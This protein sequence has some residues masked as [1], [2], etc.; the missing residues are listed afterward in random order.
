MTM[1]M[2]GN[3]ECGYTARNYDELNVLHKRYAARGLTILAFP[4]N[5]FGQ[6]E[7][8]TSSQIRQF[9]QQRVCVSPLLLVCMILALP[10]VLC[11][12]CFGGYHIGC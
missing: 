11:V 1:T 12:T 3:S 2:I 9:C 5:Q 10:K 4:S 6:Q 8:G 7:P